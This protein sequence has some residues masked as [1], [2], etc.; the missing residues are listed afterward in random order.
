MDIEDLQNSAYMKDRIRDTYS[1]DV[2]STKIFSVSVKWLEKGYTGLREYNFVTNAP[3]DYESITKMISENKDIKKILNI[4]IQPID[5]F[6]Q[7]K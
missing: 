4:D 3:V 5:F 6:N 7:V 1:G 2:V